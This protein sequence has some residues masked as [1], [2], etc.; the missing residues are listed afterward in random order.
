MLMHVGVY[1]EKI[2]HTRIILQDSSL[3]QDP[4]G[5]LYNNLIA[6]WPQSESNNTPLSTLNKHL[7]VSS[8]AMKR[9]W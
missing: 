1:V 4:V 8:D 5:A 9:Y 6:S 2:L 7:P 3:K